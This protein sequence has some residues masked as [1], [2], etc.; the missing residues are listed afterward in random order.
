MVSLVVIVTA[1]QGDLSRAFSEGGV[2]EN[3][4][5]KICVCQH[6][7]TEKKLKLIIVFFWV[8]FLIQKYPVFIII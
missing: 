8:I 7:S 5:F 6:N 2:G 1:C 4:N 3:V